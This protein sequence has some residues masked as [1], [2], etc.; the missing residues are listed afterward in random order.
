MKKP[1]RIE[2]KVSRK[3][4]INQRAPRL[5]AVPVFTMAQLEKLPNPATI[6]IQ[7][8]AL[9]RSVTSQVRVITLTK[10]QALQLGPSL[11]TLRAFL[12]VAT[13]QQVEMLRGTFPL[14]WSR[15][16]WGAER[17][18]VTLLTA[19]SGSRAFRDASRGRTERIEQEFQRRIKRLIAS[20][21]T[22]S[23]R[24]SLRV[25]MQKGSPQLWQQIDRR[26]DQI[27]REH[28]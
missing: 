5:R 6:N 8:G 3:S 24:R 28:R 1:N 27:I 10:E 9:P 25:I 26:L 14:Q 18:R 16:E 13:D 2:E 4:R 15:Q 11:P 21:K 23:L 19:L 12:R 7:S 20:V 17:G 22:P